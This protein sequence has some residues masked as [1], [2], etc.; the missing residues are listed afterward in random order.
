MKRD[1]N[2]IFAGNFH[3]A[4]IIESRA[5]RVESYVS[6]DCHISISR[7]LLLFSLKCSQI[8]R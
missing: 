7:L 6:K 2:S 5:I 3:K 4:Y 8:E 1:E